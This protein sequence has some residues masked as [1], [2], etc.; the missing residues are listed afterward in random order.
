MFLKS[1][2]GDRACPSVVHR[3]GMGFGVDFGVPLEI[4]R[5]LRDAREAAE[6]IHGK[7]KD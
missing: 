5:L 4:D 7:A 1:A 2:V 3:F 6:R